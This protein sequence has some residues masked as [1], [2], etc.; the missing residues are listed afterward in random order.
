MRIKRED[1]NKCGIYC[2]KNITTNKVYIGKSKNIYNRMMQHQYNLRKKSKDENRYLI[3][4]WHKYGEDDFEYTILEELDLNE[5]LL[6]EREDFW[7]VKFNATNKKFGYNLRRDSSTGCIVSKETRKLRSK[8]FSGKNN[9]NYGHKWS[10]EQKQEMSKIVKDGYKN[11]T[12]KVNLENSKKGIE[13]RNKRWKEHPELI[14]IMKSKISKINTKYLFYQYER[15]SGE[16]IKI[17]DSI[18]DIL[19]E[20]PTWKAHNIYSVCYGHKPSIYGY[21]W[22]KVKKDDIVQTLEKSKD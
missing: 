1:K 19:K 20:N 13:S 17:W 2:I 10:D 12:R 5:E 4:A 15:S 14:E 16:L 8:L 6:R 22:K 7:I 3:N 18:R 11:G 21:T 9:P